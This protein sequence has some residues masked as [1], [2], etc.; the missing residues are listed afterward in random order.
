MEGGMP[1]PIEDATGKV[2]LLTGANRGIGLAAAREL[3]RRGAKVVAGVRDPGK[4]PA[5]EGVRVLPLDVADGESCR[6]FVEQAESEFGRIDGLINNAGILLDAST[7]VLELAEA[8]LRR[9]LDVNLIGA[10]RMCQLVVPGMQS[11]GYGRVVNVSSGL[12]SI[13]DMGGGYPSYRMAK[14]ALNGFTRIL[15]AE[16]GKSG[17]VKVNSLCPGWVRT[18]MGGADAARDPSEP[19]SEIADLISIAA[20][21]PS[22]GFYRRGEPA[23]W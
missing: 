5:I 3:A 2:I 13:T 23:E 20:N 7:P 12:G 11:R 17:N 6:A 14:L 16:L 1:L 15:G 8:D 22:G 10:I 21:G 4:M 18:D 9:T 19:A